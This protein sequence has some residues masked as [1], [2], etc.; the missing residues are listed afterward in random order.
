MGDLLI[1]ASKVKEFIKA[2]GCHTSADSLDALSK[3]VE[4]LLGEATK[5]CKENRRS[6][7]KPAD[8]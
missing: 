1:V 5:R 2:K 6:T 4:S 7:V 8:L 3:K